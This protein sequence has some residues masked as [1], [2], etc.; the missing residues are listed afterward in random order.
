[1]SDPTKTT[2]T[3]ERLK[4]LL[5]YDPETGVFTWLPR[6]VEQFSDTKR[7]KAKTNWARWNTLYEGQRAGCLRDNEDNSVVIRV[8][9][10]T[11]LSHRLAWLYMIGG[12][13][14][15]EIDH[16]DLDRQNNDW[17]NLREATRAEQMANRSVLPQ[18][19]IGLKGVEPRGRR[20]RAYIN[21]N[22]KRVYLGNYDTIDEAS[23]AY[24]AAAI[25][26]FGE[27]ARVA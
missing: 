23:S 3:Q 12:W 15:Q 25:K 18:S 22:R 4:E 8:D 19:A 24:M 21:V 20:F 9:G 5:R 6:S 11:Y 1:M 10:R 27:F 16:K 26:H 13:P 14:K 7:F 2:L 17:S